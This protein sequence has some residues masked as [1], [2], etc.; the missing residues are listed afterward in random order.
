MSTETREHEHT[1]A[2]CGASMD[3]P[4][5]AGLCNACAI[6]AAEDVIEQRA[7]K[8]VDPE[9]ARDSTEARKRRTRVMVS[10]AVSAVCLAIIAVRA[11]VLV[12]ATASEPPRRS[13]PMTTAGDCDACVTNLW[14]ASVS[15]RSGSPVP[16]GLYCP[17]SA[18]PYVV[19]KSGEGLPTISCPNP[20][21]H[22]LAEL[23]VTSVSPIP[24]AVAP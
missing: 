10:V 9:E 7:Q 3:E 15:V 14:K 8:A 19:D 1:C 21:E 11:P 13:G 4:G 23:K 22:E 5:Y 6:S 18:K 20:G 24:Q 17:A 2:R 12:A 16:I